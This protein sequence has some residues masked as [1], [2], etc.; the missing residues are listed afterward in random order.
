MT[1]VGRID[2]HPSE[3]VDQEAIIDHEIQK[4][5]KLCTKHFHVKY[6]R[7][8]K[9]KAKLTDDAV[10]MTEQEY[11]AHVARE[12]LA[13][14]ALEQQRLVNE[15]V[16][17]DLLQKKPRPTMRSGRQP[18]S[19][20]Q[21]DD[22]PK[23]VKKCHL[24]VDST[25]IQLEVKTVALTKAASRLAALEEEMA[26][27]CSDIKS[28]EK[29]LT[30]QKIKHTFA[31]NIEKYGKAFR[32]GRSSLTFQIALLLWFARVRHNLDQ[33]VLTHVF[34]LTCTQTVSNILNDMNAVILG[35]F[36]HPPNAP[37]NLF[38]KETVD[39]CKISGLLYYSTC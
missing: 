3:N 26:Q 5:H 10:P 39:A 8:T 18:R 34:G 15:T 29:N 1:K 31:E 32:P 4:Q 25:T 21:P 24:K 30:Q 13:Y 23:T 37:I 14:E 28:A 2:E 27:L 22:N 6:I 20:I 33:G 12:R 9:Q 16:R 7:R 17:L 38:T 36:R 11:R 19:T 35:C